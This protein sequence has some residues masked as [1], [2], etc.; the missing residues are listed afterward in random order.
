MIYHLTF[1]LLPLCIVSLNFQENLLIKEREEIKI[2]FSV[3]SNPT[4]LKVHS[5]K[6]KGDCE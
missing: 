1:L 5:S 6:P 4:F 3:T 2:L